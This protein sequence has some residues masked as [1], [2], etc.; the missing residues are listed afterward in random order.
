MH[1]VYRLYTLIGTKNGGA[2][3][4]GSPAFIHPFPSSFSIFIIS[5]WSSVS[6]Q[7]FQSFISSFKVHIHIEAGKFIAIIQYFMDNIYTPQIKTKTK[8]KNLC[9]FPTLL[10][11]FSSYVTC[12]LL[13]STSYY[14]LHDFLLSSSRPRS[15]SSSSLNSGHALSSNL[16]PVQTHPQF[17]TQIQLQLQ[18]QLRSRPELN[19]CNQSQP[20]PS[21]R[22]RSSSSSS[23]SLG[24]ALSSSP[25]PSPNPSESQTQIQPQLQSHLRSRPELQSCNQS[26]PIPSPRPRSSS[27]S[28]LSLGPALS[29]GTGTG[30]RT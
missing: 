25:A 28:S 6:I 16:Q 22:P 5:Y 17:Q 4:S 2:P 27:S 26:Q 18:S 19:S 9:Y 8:T 15:S 12:K 3:N 10:Y 11:T 20:I 21:P 24:P 30:T 1:L 14:S 13:F 23:L 29:S 7:C